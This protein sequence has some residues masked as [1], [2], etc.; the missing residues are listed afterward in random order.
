MLSFKI[1][2][3]SLLAHS[4]YQTPDTLN[5]ESQGASIIPGKAIA[6]ELLSKQG[7]V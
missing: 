5:F 3:R 4:I 2:H 6:N 7:R 1:K